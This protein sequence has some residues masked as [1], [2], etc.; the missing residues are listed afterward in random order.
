[1]NPEQW[2]NLGG[3]LAAFMF[4]RSKRRTH[5]VLNDACPGCRR[6]FAPDDPVVEA[7]GPAK[8]LLLI[9]PDCLRLTKRGQFVVIRP[10]EPQAGAPS[11]AFWLILAGLAVVLL[12]AVLQ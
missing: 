5:E 9:H 4:A 11:W 7:F 12:L 8:T 10:P 6:R 3:F 2:E 1:M